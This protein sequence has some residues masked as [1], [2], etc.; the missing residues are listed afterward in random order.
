MSEVV[1]ISRAEC[2]KMKLFRIIFVIVI[3]I[4]S[5]SDV[6][7]QMSDYDKLYYGLDRP[8]KRVEMGVLGS[9]SMLFHSADDVDIDPKMGYRVALVMAFCWDERFAIQGEIGYLHH[10]SEVKT[11]AAT[12]S[13][14][15]NIC[16]VPLLFSYRGVSHLRFN[17]GP[18]I[19]LASSA[20]YES[21]GE[22]IEAGS[23]RSTVGYA[24]GIAVEITRH[25]I[26]DARYTGNFRQSLNYAGGKEFNMR[27]HWATLTL[28][29]VF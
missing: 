1:F 24:A 6:V 18:V 5:T 23:V 21:G 19:N 20:R 15:S 25:L 4:L 13:L 17:V 26:I 3:F 12:H 9:A 10:K 22:R 28:G 27:S 2:E 7:A 11:A 29:Y 16:E 8:R 14:S